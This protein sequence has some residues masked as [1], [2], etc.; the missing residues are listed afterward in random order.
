MGA[1]VQAVDET[2]PSAGLLQKNDIIVAVGNTQISS[3]SQFIHLVESA[4]A[5]Q[6][7]RLTVY[8]QNQYYEVTVTVTEAYRPAL[9]SNS[10]QNYY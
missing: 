3:S 4:Q 10:P 8:R 6:S 1:L 7:L 2:G 9:P 5:G